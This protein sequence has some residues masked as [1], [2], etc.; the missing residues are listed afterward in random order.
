MYFKTVLLPL[1]LNQPQAEASLRKAS[2]KETMS[3]DFKFKSVDIGTDKLFYG[4]DGKEDLKFTRLKTSFE[5]FMPK[6]IV[7][8]PKDSSAKYYRIRPGAVSIAIIGL[9]CFALFTG[10]AGILKGTTDIAT[11]SPFFIIIGVYALLLFFEMNITL[12]KIN[13][14]FSR[15]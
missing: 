2:I 12:R 13:K 8:L 15:V 11:F 9:L 14:A 6:L 3:L 4:L 1:E 7:S 5:F 10:L